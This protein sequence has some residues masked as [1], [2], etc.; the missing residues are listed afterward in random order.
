MQFF[1]LIWLQLFWRVA[2]RCAPG[3]ALLAA[4]LALL[5][6]H[7]V[8]LALGQSDAGLFLVLAWGLLAAL[9]YGR[10]RCAALLAAACAATRPEGMVLAAGLGALTAALWLRR[11]AQTR[12]LLPAAVTGLLTSF[13][14]L[15]LNHWLTGLWQF[16]SVAGKG[17]LNSYPLVGALGCISNDFL[18][19]WREAFFNLGGAPRQNYF[20]PVL[21]GC[22]ALLGV[23]GVLRGSPLVP[24]AMP[25]RGVTGGMRTALWLWWLG[26]CLLALGLVATSEFLGMGNDRYL[27]WI[28]PAWYLFAA[29]GV[30]QVSRMFR[31]PRLAL[32]FGLL[33][34]GFEIAAWPY[35]LARFAV[36][37]AQMQALVNFGRTADAVMPAH[38]PVGMLAGTGLRYYLGDR[39]M[40]HLNGVTSSAFRSQR[41]LLCAVET[42]RHEPALRFDY[43]LLPLSLQ[44]WCEATGMLGDNLLT[45]V[46][47]PPGEYTFGLFQAKW[48]A[49][50]AASLLP[51]DAAVAHAVGILQLVDQL[52]VGYAADE[53]RCHYQIGN[54]LPDLSHLPFVSSRKL[55]GQQITEVGQ[56]V[57]GW[58]EFQVAAPRLLCP[59]RVVL[60]TALDATCTAVRLNM[61]REGEVLHL[62]SPLQLKLLVNG[63]VLPVQDV[64]IVCGGEEFA[65]CV[66]DIPAQVVTSNPLTITIAGDHLALAYWF[67]Q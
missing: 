59:M 23:A 18:V 54:R 27:A 19:L 53:R 31:L 33:L 3:Q 13:A 39:P 48:S 46:E 12:L 47:G 5:N 32:V 9:F 60:R 25:Q 37:G 57:I 15:A 21:G 7:L 16:Q 65:E 56:P 50:P 38:A 64:S 2:R 52:D 58:D 49:Q 61:R 40:R 55:G 29:A 62:R 42:L 14:V 26:C 20:I 10:V 45:D 67:Y 28:L 4:V 34:I 51:M 41:D 66:L 44:G 36:Q 17:Y 24:S 6:G 22:L 35:F 30:G 11:N 8:L 63:V 1:Y 43:W